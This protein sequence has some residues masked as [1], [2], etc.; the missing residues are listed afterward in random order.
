MSVGRSDDEDVLLRSHPVH[1][2]E[3]LVDDAVGGAAGIPDRAASRLGD[4]VELIE[5]ED[6]G[7]GGAGLVEDV[8]HVGPAAGFI[9]RVGVFSL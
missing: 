1:L 8:A 4:G 3:D 9:W 5:E 2:R 6:A 7:R